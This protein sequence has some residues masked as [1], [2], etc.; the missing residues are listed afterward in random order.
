[1]DFFA[2]VSDA[3]V[4][5]G[6]TISTAAFGNDNEDA[7]GS[8][9]VPDVVASKE[10]TRVDSRASFASEADRSTIISTASDLDDPCRPR[11]STSSVIGG[12]SR[13]SSLTEADKLKVQ[14]KTGSSRHTIEVDEAA[15][16][17]TYIN[18]LLEGHELVAHLLPLDP[19]TDDVV[20]RCQDGLLLADLIHEVAPGAMNLKVLSTKKNMNLFQKHENNGHVLNAAK[21]IGCQVVNIGSDDLTDSNPIATLGE[22][23]N[24]LSSNVHAN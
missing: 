12:R 1:M 9:P 2:G 7:S 22:Y 11:R 5:V 10:L 21:E 4:S 24:G 3:F 15:A 18:N 13:N 16:F 20:T 23:V 14:E 6:K 8:P 17:S 19:M